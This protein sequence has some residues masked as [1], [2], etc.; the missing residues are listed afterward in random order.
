MFPVYASI[1]LPRLLTFRNTKPEGVIRRK[2]G[3]WCCKCWYCK[4]CHGERGSNDPT[5]SVTPY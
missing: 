4:D 1:A 2:R 5:D 3:A